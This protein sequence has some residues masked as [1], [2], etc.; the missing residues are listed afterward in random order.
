MFCPVLYRVLVPVPALD[1]PVPAPVLDEPVPVPFA[2]GSEPLGALV[3]S[4]MQSGRVMPGGQGCRV[5]DMPVVRSPL[6]E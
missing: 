1:E 5:L 6:S 2:P 4:E 3:E